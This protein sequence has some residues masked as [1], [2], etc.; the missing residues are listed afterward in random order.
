M[1]F[2]HTED[3][4]NKGSFEKKKKD[5]IYQT[6]KFL[7]FDSGLEHSTKPQH[8]FSQN[9]QDLYVSKLIKSTCL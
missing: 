3:E 5:S 4:Q 7:L 1:Q 9:M 6:G 2:L 8:F